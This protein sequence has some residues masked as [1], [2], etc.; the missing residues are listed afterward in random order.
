MFENILGHEKQ[1]D[2]LKSNIE[3]NNISHSYLFVGKNGIGKKSLALE[4]AK[5]ILNTNNLNNCPDFKIIEK[6]KDKKNILVE[7]IREDILKDVYIAPISSNKK[8]Y[9]V[10]DF[11]E[12]N[13]SSQNT[14]LKTLE[15][16]PKFIV[17]ILISSKIDNILP[18]I[19]SRVNIVAFN[20][21]NNELLK[22][23]IGNDIKEDILN[24]IDGSIGFYNELLEEDNFNKL[25]DINN[26]YKSIEEKNY[27]NC[28]KIQE[29]ID[30]NK[31]YN[32][33]YLIYLMNKN[34]KNLCVNILQKSYIRLQ[35]NGNY[36]IVIDNMILKCIDSISEN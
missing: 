3:S 29:N 31:Y 24:F 15:E 13:L 1:K 9:I 6:K 27:L 11:E 28:F 30:F 22:E 7:Q 32:F 2:F 34:N 12:L 18:T 36:D 25:S 14:L 20:K 5:Q 35:N 17:I 21:I 4:F 16:P 19:I 23:Y 8:V 26:L 33:N 10:N